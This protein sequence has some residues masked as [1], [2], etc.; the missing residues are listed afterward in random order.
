MSS[1]DP[2]YIG[3]MSGTSM[4]A[5]DAVIVD[6]PLPHHYRI[7]AKHHHL[8]P[9]SLRWRLLKFDANA[10]VQEFA[11]LDT[12]VARVLAEATLSLISQ[13]QLPQAR[14]AA[15]GCHGQ[16]VFHKPE[17][18]VCNSLQI[19]NPALIAERTGLPIVSDFRR[20]DIAAGGQG[21]PLVPAFQRQFMASPLE[22][23]VVLNIGG[24]ANIAVLPANNRI[25][26]TGFDTGPGNCLLDG[27]IRRHRQLPYDASGQWARSGKICLALL[28]ALLSHPF[29]SLAPP[30]STGKDEFNLDWLLPFCAKYAELLPAEDIQATLMELTAITIAEAIEHYA[31]ETQRVL[32][33]GGGVNNQA[34]VERISELLSPTA[35]RSTLEIGI[36]PQWVE[37]SAFAWLAQQRLLLQAGNVPTVTGAHRH[38]ILGALYPA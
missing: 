24:I 1:V 7:L 29:F 26:V 33:C 16:T 11:E 15:V 31:R 9:D 34:L 4:D 32:I 18:P 20:G 38:V 30:K 27:W 13:S 19:G 28:D 25:P 23:R 37:A 2:V 22:N 5:V 14:F 10:T 17:D 6:F 35:V 8:F 21:A 36:D 3:L 12:Q